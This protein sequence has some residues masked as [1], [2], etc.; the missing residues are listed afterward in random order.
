MVVCKRLV[1]CRV[2]S[3]RHGGGTRAWAPS[4]VTV[5]CRGDRYPF[6]EYPY[7][8][9]VS[10]NRSRSRLEPE[11]ELIDAMG[12]AFAAGHYWNVTFEYCKADQ[13]V[14]WHEAWLMRVCARTWVLGLGC[15]HVDACGR[16]G[17]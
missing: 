16:R 11:Y 7:A 4:C 14:D 13:Q 17:G 8:D 12:P 15:V 10:V 9:L 5:D 2:C 3:P 1:C 6:D